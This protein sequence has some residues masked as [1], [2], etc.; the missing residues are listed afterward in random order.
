MDEIREEIKR[1]E[2]EIADLKKMIGKKTLKPYL[3]GD[4]LDI[5]PIGCR[6]HIAKAKDGGKVYEVYRHSNNAPIYDLART[7]FKFRK[8]EELS[9][10]ELKEVADFCNE[11]IPI[12]NKYAVN[13]YIVNFDIQRFDEAY[14]DILDYLIVRGKPRSTIR[15]WEDTRERKLRRIIELREELNDEET[16]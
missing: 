4:I 14:Q 15:L 5:T 2:V 12:Y 7:L 13:K 9:E 16:S 10:S 11:I 3:V 1:L 6:G 8:I